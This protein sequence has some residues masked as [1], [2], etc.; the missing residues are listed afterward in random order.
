MTDQVGLNALLTTLSHKKQIAFVL[1]LLERMFAAL[2]EFA[3]ATGFN[4]SCYIDARQKAWDT[5]RSG[6]ADGIAFQS[7]AEACLSSAPDTEAYSHELTSYALNVAIAM[8]EILELIQDSR[9]DH[10]RSIMGL[11]TDSVYLY[12]S[13]IEPSYIS[14]SAEDERIA[15]HPLMQ[16]ERRREEADIRFLMT[17]PDRFDDATISNLRSRAK[18]SELLPHT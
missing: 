7:L 9:M 16:E 4:I 12:R 2:T 18:N 3:N 15:A 17:L 14:T 8:S 1:L 5:L 6:N 10:I 11:A 13:S